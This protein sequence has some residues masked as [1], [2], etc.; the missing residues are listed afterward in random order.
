MQSWVCRLDLDA[1]TYALIP[2]TSRCYLKP[3]DDEREGGK[4]LLSEDGGR[5]SLSP[6]CRVALE[7]VFHR[8]DLDGNGFISRTE[9]DFFQEKTSGEICDDEAWKVIQGG[10]RVHM[11]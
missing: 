10:H 7:E 2:F 9:F 6:E 11:Y 3:Q 4:A 5:V 1:G 8:M